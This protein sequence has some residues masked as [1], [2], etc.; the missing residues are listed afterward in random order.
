[1]KKDI[2]NQNSS[3]SKKRKRITPTFLS[4]V[5]IVSLLGF[6]LISG[7]FAKYLH[8]RDTD[9]LAKSKEFYF[10]SDY[11]TAEGK[12]YTLNP[13]TKSITFE[14]RNYEGLNTSEIDIS[15]TVSVD[16]DVIVTYL[17]N[18]KIDVAEKTE[19]VT[20]SGL[21]SGKTYNVT[22]KG[23]NGYEHTLKATFT[24]ENT[25]NGIFKNTANYGDYVILTV[26]TKGV[27]ATVD[28]TVPEGLIPDATDDA[29]TGKVAG[30]NVQMTL[31][32]YTSHSF[33]FFTT[34]SYINGEITVTSGGDTLAETTLS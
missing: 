4:L 29:L 3:A 28:F 13:Y 24:V 16:Q 32:E 34:S 14:L 1:M 31:N 17:G 2:L 5:I 22:V 25:V 27:S 10:T 7:V 8:S 23:E 18:K 21:E 15:Y 19:L 30:S 12:T 33:R 26:W 6:G 9:A 11:L 20:I